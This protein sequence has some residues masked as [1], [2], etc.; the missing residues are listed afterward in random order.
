MELEE[1]VWNG[2]KII[3]LLEY[4]KSNTTKTCH[5]VKLCFVFVLYFSTLLV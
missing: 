4:R 5:P 1:K 3:L 2:L